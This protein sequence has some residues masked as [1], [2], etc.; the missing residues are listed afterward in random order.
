MRSFL[1]RSAALVAALWLLILPA[2]AGEPVITVLTA[3]P[4][5]ILKAAPLR[6]ECELGQTAADALRAVSGA[7]VALVNGGDLSGDLNTGAVTAADIERVF[8]SDR[9]LA[10]A[11]VTAAQLWSLLEWSVHAIA[12]DPATETVIE[13]DSDFEGFCHVSGV[14][15]VYDASAPAP[16]RV[17]SLTL[18]DGRKLLPDDDE[19]LLRVCATEEMLSGGYGYP[20]LSAT[21]NGETLCSALAAYAAGKTALPE[22]SGARIVAVGARE[23]AL[24]GAV[25]RWVLVAG[26]AVLIVLLAVPGRK[27]GRYR[28]EFE[29]NDEKWARGYRKR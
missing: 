1:R 8:S 6:A 13:A 9:P 2:L 19:T 14:R 16:E 10:V 3:A 21:A 18:D 12:V 4:Q 28:D 24:V 11:E 27:L 25:P 20:V 5:T 26:C 7:D 17:Q 23:N 15:V 29:P 22:Q